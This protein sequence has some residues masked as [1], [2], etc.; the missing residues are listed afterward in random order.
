MAN[1]DG[2]W[3][4]VSKVFDTKEFGYR[5]IKV[6]RPLQLS[7]QATPERIEALKREKPFLASTQPI[8]K[9]C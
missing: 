9:H 3:A 4:E 7:F 5:E 6:E 1:G 2:E 8:R